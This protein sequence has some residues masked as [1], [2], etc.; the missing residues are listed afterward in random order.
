MFCQEQGQQSEDG[1]IHQRHNPAQA[2]LG[3][4]ERSRQSLHRENRDPIRVTTQPR[5]AYRKNATRERRREGH[6]QSI[7]RDRSA[8]FRPPRLGSASDGTAGESVRSTHLAEERAQR[9]GALQHAAVG[10]DRVDRRHRVLKLLRGLRVG[11]VQVVC[12][13]R[14]S[15]RGEGKEML[16]PG[17][18]AWIVVVANEYTA[19][20]GR[21]SAAGT[22]QAQPPGRNPAN[23]WLKPGQTRSNS[24]SPRPCWPWGRSQ[25]RQCPQSGWTW[26]CRCAQARPSASGTCCR[27]VRRASANG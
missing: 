18:I 2:D 14:I 17:R 1:G 7:S 13:V 27:G 9:V 19:K 15:W 5:P 16:Q 25:C 10:A 21:T 24:N 8:A 6:R 12:A 26:P 11:C 20:S 4:F 22:Q 23:P 3:N